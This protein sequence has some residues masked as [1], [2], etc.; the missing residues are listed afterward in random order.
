[1]RKYWVA[2][3]E[4]DVGDPLYFGKASPSFVG[5]TRNIHFAFK[6][7]DEAEVL[8]VIAE[9]GLEKTVATEIVEQD[10]VAPI[11]NL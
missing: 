9:H 2:K 4:A 3:S 7:V 1:M 5:F 8:R 6:F 11:K 10:P